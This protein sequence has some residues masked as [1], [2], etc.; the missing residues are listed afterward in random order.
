[1]KRRVGGGK[2]GGSP[3]EERQTNERNTPK[4]KHAILDLSH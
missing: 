2:R 4:S 3:K 1:M